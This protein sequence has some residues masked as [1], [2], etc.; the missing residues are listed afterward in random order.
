MIIDFSV[1]EDTI[2]QPTFKKGDLAKT[3]TSYFVDIYLILNDVYPT[4][5]R[6][7]A[8]FIGYIDKVSKY[9]FLFNFNEDMVKAFKKQT[10]RNLKLQKLKD[11]EKQM[12][13]DEMNKKDR[14]KILYDINK[15]LK[16]IEEYIGF[17]LKELPEL[18]DYQIRN[19]ANKYNL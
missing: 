1:F 10:T 7:E 11:N 4:D 14:S 17:D 18:V 15:K 2:S 9:N 16:I 12:I 13:L 19:S 3:E 5:E 6:A 8:F